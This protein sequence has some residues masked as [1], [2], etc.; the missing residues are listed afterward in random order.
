MPI[1]NKE[2]WGLLSVLLTVVSYAPYFIS[3]LKGKTHPHVFTWLIWVISCGIAAAAQ[4]SDH[5]GPGT[6]S[7]LA[8]TLLALVVVVLCFRQKADWSITRSDW[9][10]LA[11]GLTIIPFWYL[12]QSALLAAIL[13][14]AIDVC[15]YYPTLRK[16]W[17][18][19]HEEMIS[20]YLIANVKHA[21]SIAATVH[22]SWTT[23]IMPA[24]TLGINIV[25][26]SLVLWRRHVVAARTGLSGNL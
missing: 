18:K 21:A 17:N 22:Y 5:A 9:I 15:A 4:Y 19:P 8:S 7:N 24:T 14:T 26:I 16:S 13:A 1:L 20:L 12:T 3:T 23:V 6:L 25:L 11:A 10:A 2:I